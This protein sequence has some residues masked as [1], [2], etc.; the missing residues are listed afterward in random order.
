M[1]LLLSSCRLTSYRHRQS[2][3]LDTGYLPGEVPSYSLYRSL[4]RLP[5]FCLKLG[6]I[7]AN[8]LRTG[9]RIH[10]T[11][12][13]RAELTPPN[14]E[15]RF[16]AEKENLMK[17]IRNLVTVAAITGTAMLAGC[18]TSQ[19]IQVVQAGDP[20]LSCASLKEEIGKLDKAQAEIDSKKGVTG[21]NVAA[22]L[23]WLPGLAYTY[24]DA[25]EAQR[26]ISDR[27]SGLT[28]IYNSKK[29]N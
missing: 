18:A 11:V 13:I 2:W 26:L 21:T 14:L 17:S 22:A 15:Q 25:G 23:F 12:E 5:A 1:G 20:T 29:C 3:C 6:P 27:K 4:H 24:Y 7:I 19:K 8:L 28:T 16:R 10:L 9:W